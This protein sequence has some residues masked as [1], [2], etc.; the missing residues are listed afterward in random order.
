MLYL[1]REKGVEGVYKIGTSKHVD[2]RV[3]EHQTGNSREVIIEYAWEGTHEDE[4]RLHRVLRQF[5]RE[6]GGTEFFNISLGTLLEALTV[7]SRYHEIHL[8][9]PNRSDVGVEVGDYGVVLIHEGQWRGQRALYM[10][11]FSDDLAKVT[12]IEG[13]Q[14]TFVPHKWLR[15]VSRLDP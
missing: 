9:N 2:Q 14:D 11:D 4:A 8:H 13:G 12:I 15:M 6:E 10:D 5:K 1:M 7:E 3:R